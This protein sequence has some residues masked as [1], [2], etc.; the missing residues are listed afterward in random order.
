VSLTTF[1][2]E[3]M[4]SEIQEMADKIESADEQLSL[5]KPH[6]HDGYEA[7]SLDAVRRMVYTVAQGYL[8]TTIDLL[9]I[10]HHGEGMPPEEQDEQC[11]RVLAVM[12]MLRGREHLRNTYGV[13]IAPPGG[14]G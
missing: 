5:G 4:I 1:E 3:Q 14:V 10:M 6:L 11:A 13:D 9:G 12:S 8:R 7:S 2:L